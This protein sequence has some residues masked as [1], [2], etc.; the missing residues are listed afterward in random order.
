MPDE[1][2]K[3]IIKKGEMKRRGSE[4]VESGSID[5]P[6]GWDLFIK[7]HRMAFVL[8]VV[9]AFL[10]LVWLVLVFLWFVGQAQMN[11][12]VPATLNLWTIGHVVSFLLNL[13]FW[14]IVLVGIPVAIGAGAGWYW[15][16]R[17]PAEERASYRRSRNRSRGSDAGNGISFLVFIGF[18]IKVYLDG[19]WNVPIA[20]WT[21]DYLVYSWITVIVWL[22]I[23]A[24]IPG[25]IVLAW[26]VLRGRR[27]RP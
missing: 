15:F 5:G 4:M 7:Q 2:E 19:N 14:I 26:W 10:A 25:V 23:I 3:Y 12:I 20:T 1:L 24:A 18:L 27:S 6:T 16:R 17:L 9:A 13:L 8:F 11:G 22:F 21:F